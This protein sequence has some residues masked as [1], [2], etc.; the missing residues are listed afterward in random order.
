MLNLDSYCGKNSAV[1]D[2]LS[3]CALSSQVVMNL[4]KPFLETI[5]PG[6]IPK[7]H[8]YFDNYFTNFDLFVHLKQLGLQC[9]GTIQENR[10]KERNVINTIRNRPEVGML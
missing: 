9:T 8:L 4:L 1:T 6:K 5:A 7:I 2:K 3:K 10:M